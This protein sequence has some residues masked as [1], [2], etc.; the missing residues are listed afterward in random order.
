MSF[1]KKCFCSFY[2]KYVQEPFEVLQF[3][4][5]IREE[6]FEYSTIY[7]SD[8]FLNYGCWCQILNKNHGRGKPKDEL[9][10]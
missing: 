6:N 8:Q 10:R 9:D 7:D 5:L 3:Y 1:L 4:I 2:I